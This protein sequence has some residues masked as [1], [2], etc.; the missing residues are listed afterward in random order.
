MLL[1]VLRG[2]IV[3]MKTIG[4]KTKP[5]LAQLVDYD[6]AWVTAI[7]LDRTTFITPISSIKYIS[8]ASP[9][10]I[11]LYNNFKGKAE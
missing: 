3:R 11:D 7:D 10:Q 9:E 8:P 2:E 5:F 4:D 1:S 6:N